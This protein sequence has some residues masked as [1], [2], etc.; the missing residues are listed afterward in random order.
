MS[1]IPQAELDALRQRIPLHQLLP[2]AGLDRLSLDQINH[3]ATLELDLK[4][5]AL[6]RLKARHLCMLPAWKASAYGTPKALD[7]LTDGPV[8]HVQ[9]VEMLDVPAFLRRHA[10]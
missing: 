1:H 7:D 9:G 5:R 8:P 4:R 10:D 3:P 2:L 6:A